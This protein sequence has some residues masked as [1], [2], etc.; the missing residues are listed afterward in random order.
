M[1]TS[2]SI[3]KRTAR[4]TTK[5]G[6]ER[7]SESWYAR[8][9]DEAG[10]EHA[11]RFKRKVDATRWLD[12]VT[13]S[14]VTGNYVD[15]KAGKITFQRFYADWSARQV[16]VPST[17]VGADHAAGSV[18]FAA[19]PLKSIRRS[20][21]EAWVKTMSS[22]L[23]ATTIKTRFVI[24][25]SVFRAAVADKVI[26]SDP[27]EGIT[28]P[29]RRKQEAAMRIPTVDEVGRL[30]GAADED[31]RSFVALCAFAGL[32][33]GE[34]AGVQVGDIDF[35]RRQLTVSRQLQRDGRDV[36]V[37]PPKYGSERVVY[38]PDELVTMLS[39]HIGQHTPEGEPGRWLFTA[40][41]K[42][43]HNNRITFQWRTTRKRA[44]AETVRLHDLR[45]FYASGLIAQGCDV[46]TVQRALGHSTATTTLN[47]Y[48]HLWPT[49]EDRTRSAAGTLMSEALAIPAGSTRAV[50]VE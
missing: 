16:W 14:I 12:E 48:S 5:D 21:V 40:Y 42:P 38:L 15:P 13:A 20:H 27:T 7:T 30:L 19:V 36:A 49:A 18:P 45:H 46:V 47:T 6:Q 50:V 4:W 35:L 31:F 37:V 9:R 17:R 34:A 24:V 43:V 10:K 26:A 23:A 39:Q 3:Q 32:R 22:E 11:R 1:A 41:G 29:R 33:M 28:L 44:T 8:Y 25:R 2:K